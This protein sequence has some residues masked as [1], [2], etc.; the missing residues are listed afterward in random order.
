MATPSNKVTIQFK[1]NGESR[2]LDVAPNE[3]LLE[4][5]RDRVGVKSPKC[6]CDAGD[7]GTCTVMID[8][9]TIRSC[10]ALAVELDGTEVTTI[11]GLMRPGPAGLDLHP[12]QQ[13]FVDRNVF[14][15]GFCAPGVTL[16]AAELLKH[17]K[18]PTRE[19]VQ[20]GIGGNLCRCTGYQPIIDAVLEHCKSH[21][22]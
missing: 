18:T 15:C 12:L 21:K 1:L 19:E 14:Q 4:T 5:L 9:R 7:C 17:N 22:A 8:G 3:V 11:E 6:G 16:S 2:T 20:E 10:L 13:L